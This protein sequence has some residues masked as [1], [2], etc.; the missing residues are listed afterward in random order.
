MS[1]RTYIEQL[2]QIREEI[3]RQ[4]DRTPW[5]DWRREAGDAVRRDPGLSR[6]MEEAVDPQARP[7]ATPGSR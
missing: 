2:R 6:L 1:E 7:S 4:L 5:E 3:A